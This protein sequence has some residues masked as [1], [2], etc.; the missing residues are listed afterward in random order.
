MASAPTNR[1]IEVKLPVDDVEALVKRIGHL[2][3][4]GRGRVFEQNTL[5]DTS[6]SGLRRAGCLLRVRV[7]TPAGTSISPPGSPSAILTVKA[8]PSTTK[9]GRRA[10]T[11]RYKERLETETVIHHPASWDRKLKQLGFRPAFRYE[12]YRTTFRLPGLHLDLDETPV[13]DFLELEGN[14]K[15]IERVARALGYRPAD[16]VRATY[17]DLYSAYCKRTGRV[18][19]NMVFDT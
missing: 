7:E 12:K 8:P 5:Y 17:W 1:E 16:Y 4:A 13:G 11:S 10:T 15:A 3:A 2:R 6:E 9:T 19:G 18:P 14:P